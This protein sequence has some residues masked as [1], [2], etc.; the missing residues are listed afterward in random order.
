MLDIK[1][2]CSLRNENLICNIRSPC[3][4]WCSLRD[5]KLFSSTR[6]IPLSVLEKPKRVCVHQ[7]LFY[8]SIT[9]SHTLYCYHS[10]CVSGFVT[11][12]FKVSSFSRFSLYC[13]EQ[14]C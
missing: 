1:K 14:K 12:H 6:N 5:Q 4:S 9:L 8:T 3:F 11:P 7:P 13:K 2:E 10:H